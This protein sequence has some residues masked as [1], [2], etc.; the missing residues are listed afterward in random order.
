M[1]QNSEQRQLE[2]YYVI[3]IVAWIGAFIS[4]SFQ[5]NSKR[6]RVESFEARCQW[7]LLS[8]QII[9]LLFPLTVLKYI[10]PPV[11]KVH[12]GSLSVS[13][14]HQTLTWTTGSLACV[15]VHSCACVYTRGLG[16]PTASP[17]NIFDSEKLTIF[18]RVLLVGFELSPMDLE[19]DALPIEPPHH[20]KATNQSGFFL[21]P[22]VHFCPA[23]AAVER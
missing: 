14:I 18:F 1:G 21:S 22:A 20:P 15:R 17:H 9:T 2:L 11:S 12:A 19:S 5:I 6:C 10:N 13:A 16:T 3:I 8:V 7:A 23:C 4:Q